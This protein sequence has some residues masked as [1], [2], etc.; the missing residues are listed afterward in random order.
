MG[1]AEARR[2]QQRGSR[3]ATR[4]KRGK[5]GRRDGKSGIRRFFTWKKMLGGF[6]TVCL[7]GVGTFV[8][9][10]LYVDIPKENAAAVKQSNVY[11]YS[12]GSLIAH[13]GD[14]NREVVP[15]G[16]VPKDVQH[17]FVAAEN[18]NFYDDSG[19]DLKGT[20]RGLLNTLKGKGK[21]GGSTITQQY[22]KNH[23]LT[24]EQTVS[25][26]VKELFV[27]LKVDEKYDKDQIL[28][29]YMNTSY[30]GRDAYG[31]QAAAQAYYGVDVEKLT[32]EQGAYLAALLQ[33]PGQYDW[34]T[35]TDTSKKLVEKRWNYV[36]TNMVEKKWLDAGERQGKKFDKPIAPKPA[37]GLD[38][39]IGY[40]VEAAKREI[41]ASGVDEDVLGAGG[42]TITLNIDKKKQQSL[43]RAVAHKL[44][45]KLDPK[46]RAVDA[47]VQ[48]GAASVDPKTGRVLALYG[49]GDYTK[50]YLDNATRADYQPASTFKPFIL[51]AALEQDAKTQDGLPIVADTVYDG[52]SKRPVKGS[53]V[54]FAPPNEDN[55]DYGPISVQKAMNSSVNSVFAQMAVDVGLDEV[56]ETAIK[57][58]LNAKAGGFDVK[59]AMSLGVMGV[60]PLDMAG[61][62]ASLD[63]HGKKVTPQIVKS[64]HRIGQQAKLPDPIGD[65]VVSRETA[66]TV[67]SVLTGVV[68]E[69]T[70]SA[71]RTP[72]QQVA[73]KTGTSDDNKSAWFIGYTPRLVTSVGLFGEAAKTAGDVKQ[74]QQVSLKG[75]G[76]E[77]RLNGGDYPALIWAAYTQDVLRGST[78]A[79]FSLDTK[80]GAALP[81]PPKPTPTPTAPKPAP[82]PTRTKETEKPTPTPTPTT[83]TPTPTPTTGTPTPTGSA[84][85]PDPPDGTATGDADPGP[86]G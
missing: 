81:P 10:Y 8:G 27:S 57:L 44:T 12:D 67:T 22:V 50:H 16:K 59:P 55:H 39:Q 71:V 46:A 45:D 62:Y 6:L 79:K 24:Q 4:N 78:P 1:R 29:G 33:A 2:A 28:V 51:A 86:A 70:G 17:A 47:D 80:Q 19:V 35:A 11:K 66:D 53:R 42:W 82:T 73:G 60:S 49:G 23:Y 40:F 5:R 72:S 25:R 26:K 56:K 85:E 64:A 41:I 31:I 30:Y 38:G 20:V 69:G 84:S 74:G 7:L 32:V 43:E 54:G 48:A 36:L 75:A 61:A 52:T 63:N 37:K 14:V 9:L 18:K 65:Q 34:A 21:Q 77:G 76:G 58:G 83:P 15:I 13:T 3:R 68:D